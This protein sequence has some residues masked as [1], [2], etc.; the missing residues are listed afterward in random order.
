VVGKTVQT[1]AVYVTNLA[2]LSLFLT[3][4]AETMSLHS[5]V[6]EVI[7]SMGNGRRSNTESRESWVRRGRPIQKLLG[8]AR[9]RTGPATPHELFINQSAAELGTSVSQASQPAG[10][11][12]R[13]AFSH[14]FPLSGGR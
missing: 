8:L 13:N 6:L 2:E 3:A 9:V 5:K 7:H 11:P 10:Q 14:P 12:V 4:L 1:T